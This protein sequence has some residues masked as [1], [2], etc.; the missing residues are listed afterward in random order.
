MEDSTQINVDILRI[1]TE[2]DDDRQKTSEIEMRRVTGTIAIDSVSMTTKIA[3]IG[4]NLWH[5]WRDRRN[6]SITS[7]KSLWPY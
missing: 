6:F 7:G 5:C 2:L 3:S 4:I 1:L